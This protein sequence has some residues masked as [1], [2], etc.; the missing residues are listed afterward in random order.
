MEHALGNIFVR[1]FGPFQKGEGIKGHKH[2]V[3]H[4][5]YISHGSALVEQ[6]TEALI[7]QPAGSGNIV[8]K[9][10]AE[11][12]QEWHRIR[13]QTNVRGTY[14]HIPKNH[15]HSF[16]ANQPTFEEAMT[17][18]DAMPIDEIKRRLATLMSEPLQGVCIYAHRTPQ[19]D[20]VETFTGWQDA[21]S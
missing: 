7:E 5:T 9:V 13:N 12:E 3:D 17:E 14:L 2:K 10:S 21:I 1:P 16:T 18:I 4:V 15:I 6:F 8:P 19:G 11:G 20:V